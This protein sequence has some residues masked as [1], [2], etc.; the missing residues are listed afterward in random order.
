MKNGWF[1]NLDNCDTC[2][3]GSTGL[4]AC[5]QDCNVKWEAAT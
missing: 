5:T 1:S 2:V 4:E 3:G